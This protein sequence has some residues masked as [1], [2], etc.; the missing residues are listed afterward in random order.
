MYIW[1]YVGIKSLTK[2][3]ESWNDND[4]NGFI[5]NHVCKINSNGVT[6]EQVHIYKQSNNY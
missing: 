3:I 1:H 2:A 4:T 5:S 6:K